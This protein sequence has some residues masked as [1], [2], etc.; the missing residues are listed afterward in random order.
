MKVLDCFYKY[1]MIHLRNAIKSN[2]KF[3]FGVG[4][5]IYERFIWK[6]NIIFHHLKD[7]SMK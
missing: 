7:V 2:F 1:Y 3:V 6:S 4:F 5:F